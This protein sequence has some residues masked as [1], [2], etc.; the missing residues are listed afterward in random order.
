MSNKIVTSKLQ[1][2]LTGGTIT[3]TTAEWEI[4][5]N[6]SSTVLKEGVY[7]MIR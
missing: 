1:T 4:L 6:V 7:I 2:L 3:I 5:I